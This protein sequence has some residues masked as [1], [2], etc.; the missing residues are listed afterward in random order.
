[1]SDRLTSPKKGESSRRNLNL[2]YNQ[3]NRKSKDAKND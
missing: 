1:M 2:Y 3:N